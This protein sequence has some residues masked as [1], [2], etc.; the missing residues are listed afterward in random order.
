ME[1]LETVDEFMR[2]ICRR[3]LTAAAELTSETLKYHNVPMA[4]VY[5]RQAMIDTL[6]TVVNRA[7]EV[8]WVVHNQAAGGA[9]VLN[10][11]TDR[12]RRGTRWYEIDVAGVFRVDGTGRI[13]LWRDYF[14]LSHFSERFAEF[15]TETP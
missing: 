15:F 8:D 1:P 7:D 9:L 11:R 10:D 13:D 12:F 14:D 5:G 6:G 4:P 2:L 3:D